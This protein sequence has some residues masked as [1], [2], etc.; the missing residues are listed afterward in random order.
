MRKS[1]IVA[2]VLV[3]TAVPATVAASPS[4]ART[5]ARA[6][7][8]QRCAFSF[9]HRVTRAQ[10]RRGWK[11]RFGAR[12]S[13]RQPAGRLEMGPSLVSWG[14]SKVC[15]R[16]GAGW[17]VTSALTA[18]EKAPG[19]RTLTVTGRYFEARRRRHKV[20]VTFAVQPVG[21]RLYGFRD[22]NTKKCQKQSADFYGCDGFSRVFR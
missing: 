20:W 13:C 4:G 21:S 10:G 15:P 16:C 12:I 11:V 8:G 17:Y 1:L 3:S 5:E 6:A 22:T 14:V 2:A 18:Y 9:I 7:A 19:R